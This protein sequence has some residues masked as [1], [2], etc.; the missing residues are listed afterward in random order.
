MAMSLAEER[1][2]SASSGEA[3][4]NLGCRDAGEDCFGKMVEYGKKGVVIGTFSFLI[5]SCQQLARSSIAWIVCLNVFFFSI[6]S[7]LGGVYGGVHFCFLHTKPGLPRPSIL[8]YMAGKGFLG[9]YYY[10]ATQ[11]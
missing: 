1:G 7:R 6:V 5:Y 8:K 4:L 3:K 11:P 9:G 2:S 10:S